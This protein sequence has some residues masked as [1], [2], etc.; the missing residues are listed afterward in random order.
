MMVMTRMIMNH[1]GHR[2][3]A[4]Q[5]ILCTLCQIVMNWGAVDTQGC[6]I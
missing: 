1:D 5:D 6:H 2:T 3:L 4:P